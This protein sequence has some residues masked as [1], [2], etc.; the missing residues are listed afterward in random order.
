M[1]RGEVHT[2]RIAILASGSGTTAEAYARAIH[3]GQVD[4]EI[5]LVVASKMSAGILDRVIRWNRE[6]GFDTEAVPINSRLFPD[7][8]RDRGQTEEESEEICRALQRSTIDLVVQLGYMVIGNDPYISEWGFV[9]GRDSSPYEARALNTHPGSLP[10]TADTHGDGASEV[11]I[12]RFRRGEITEAHHTVHVVAQEVDGG[13]IVAEHPV[14]IEV[15]DT[16]ETLF[17][18]IQLVEKATIGYA[19]SNFIAKQREYQN[20][21]S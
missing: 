1:A 8:P 11:M 12:Q 16:K 19:I 15:G 21:N 4:A 5:G 7:R 9:P 10:L 2:P 17:N 6:W 14:P 20:A 18:R 3:E 13:P